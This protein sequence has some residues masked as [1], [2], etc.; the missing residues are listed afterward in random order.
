MFLEAGKRKENNP[1]LSHGHK[2]P[3][4]AEASL[5]KPHDIN[6]CHPEVGTVMIPSSFSWTAGGASEEKQA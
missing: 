6:S 4:L 3:I 2:Y 1:V 5:G